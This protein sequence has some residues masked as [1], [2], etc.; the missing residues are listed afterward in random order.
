MRVGILWIQELVEE[1][2]IEVRKVHG[3][4]TLLMLSRRTCLPPPWI[5]TLKRWGS[6]F[7]T[8]AQC[9]ALPSRDRFQC[10][11]QVR[12]S[13]VLK[14][15]LTKEECQ[16]SFFD[17]SLGRPEQDGKLLHAMVLCDDKTIVDSLGVPTQ[18]PLR[19]QE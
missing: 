13:L 14:S 4:A 9:P 11:F 3:H 18:L 16:S 2:E 12:E 15:A 17:S 7:E 1:G 8:V 5:C 10:N 6:S 19:E